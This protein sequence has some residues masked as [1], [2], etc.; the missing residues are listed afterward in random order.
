MMQTESLIQLWAS[1][2]TGL[3][4]F[5]M[6]TRQL[7]DHVVHEHDDWVGCFNFVIPFGSLFRLLLRPLASPWVPSDEQS[8]ED[9]DVCVP[10][11]DGGGRADNA[12]EAPPSALP[13]RPLVESL[14]QWA[15]DSSLKRSRLPQ[16]W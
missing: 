4:A 15:A 3:Q 5:D 13:W 2:L 1:L 12:V 6:Q 9:D 14:R 16:V 10:C 7:G 8:E 11:N